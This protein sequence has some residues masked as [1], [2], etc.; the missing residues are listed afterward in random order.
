MAN[1]TGSRQEKNATVVARVRKKRAKDRECGSAYDGRFPVGWIKNS[2]LKRPRA[3]DNPLSRGTEGCPFRREGTHNAWGVCLLVCPIYTATASEY[4]TEKSQCVAF[5][6][7]SFYPHP[8]SLFLAFSH[9]FRIS[10]SLLSLEHWCGQAPD[11]LWD[12]SGDPD[13]SVHRMTILLWKSETLGWIEPL[14]NLRGVKLRWRDGRHVC[15]RVP[16]VYRRWLNTGW[17]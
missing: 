6:F 13:Q 10:F 14:Y 2:V 12:P 16:N 9:I 5:S 1:K 3:Q 8:L 15:L 7:C 11:A 17:N 4:E